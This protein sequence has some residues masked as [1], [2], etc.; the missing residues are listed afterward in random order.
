MG[1]WKFTGTEDEFFPVLG[2]TARPGEVYDFGDDEPP[3]EPLA[4]GGQLSP[5]PA[6]KWVSDAGPATD[7]NL[8]QAS[9]VKNIY[10]PKLP[11][12]GSYAYGTDGNISTDP[13]GIAYTWNTD[14]TVHTETLNGVTRTYTYNADGSIASVA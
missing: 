7:F 10:I 3:R 5:I 12:A 13:D 8:K 9:D 6:S 2:L 4:K 1:F 14:G 11:T